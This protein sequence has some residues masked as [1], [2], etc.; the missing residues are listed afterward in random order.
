MHN[1]LYCVIGPSASGKSD[2][3]LKLAHAFH[4]HRQPAAIV[5]VDVMQMYDGLPIATNKPSIEEREGVP[6]YF[7]GHLCPFA[8]SADNHPNPESARHY[9]TE[10]NIV[11]FVPSAI[12][13]INDL[14]RRE[15]VV[16]VTGGT[17]YYIQAILTECIA[18]PSDGD[19]PDVLEMKERIRSMPHDELYAELLHR[20]AD[21]ASRWHPNDYRHIRRSLEV[22]CEQAASRACP[23]AD[24]MPPVRWRDHVILWIDCPMDVLDDRIA[25]RT[26]QMDRRGLCAEVTHFHLRNFDPSGTSQ[27]AFAGAIGYR[28]FGPYLAFLRSQRAIAQQRGGDAGRQRFRDSTAQAVAQWNRCLNDL[29]HK[30]KKYCTKQNRWIHNKLLVHRDL[31]VF[32]VAPGELP[33]D[34]SALCLAEVA[35]IFQLTRAAIEHHPRRVRAEPRSREMNRIRL[36]SIC[37]KYLENEAQFLAHESSRQHRKN[38]SKRTMKRGTG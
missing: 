16:I 29:K 12:S 6:H 22:I 19:L 4:E 33:S 10:H 25:R 5:C 18:L 14:R 23:S 30:T 27:T 15:V 9:G 28:E 8:S 2:F 3:A 34:A 1:R 17:L 24:S 20:D 13:L 38:L 36:C 32:R 21:V 26:Q 35:E 11:K 7:I 31:I 37:E